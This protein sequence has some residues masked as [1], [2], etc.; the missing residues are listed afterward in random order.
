VKC[1]VKKGK[2]KK[3][4]RK[5]FCIVSRACQKEEDEEKAESAKGSRTVISACERGAGAAALKARRRQAGD[6]VRCD[7]SANEGDE[8][9]AAL[10]R[11]AMRSVGAA[12]ERGKRREAKRVSICFGFF[13]LKSFGCL[14]SDFKFKFKLN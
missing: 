7:V 10:D 5:F 11:L 1:E 14:D 2:K 3:K 13:P 8:R 12:M 9:R 6:D 4:K